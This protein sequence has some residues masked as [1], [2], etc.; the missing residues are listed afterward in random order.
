MRHQTLLGKILAAHLAGRASR[1]TRSRLPV[2]LA[3]LE[4]WPTE[5][6]ARRRE[7]ALKRL[8]HAAKARLSS[9]Y[10]AGRAKAGTEEG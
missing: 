4:E 7:A 8:G 1:Y 6:E 9:G 2:E 10:A 5:A 3:Y